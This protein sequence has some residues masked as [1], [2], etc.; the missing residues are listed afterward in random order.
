MTEA[1]HTA[2]RE[3]KKP[4]KS[5]CHYPSK[6][7]GRGRRLKLAFYWKIK[8]LILSPEKEG[9]KKNLNPVL[10]PYHEGDVILQGRPASQSMND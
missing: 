5:A 4:C 1:T 8:E 2:K 3:S 9:G 6:R 10:A 7:S